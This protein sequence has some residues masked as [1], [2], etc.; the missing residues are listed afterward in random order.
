VENAFFQR[1]QLLLGQKRLEKLQNL[2][3]IIFG[4]GGVGSWCAE[5]LIRSGVR[6]LTI[7]D[8]DRVC[9]T[10]V[11]RQLQAT[12]MT[13][14]QVKTEVLKNRLLE[15][16]PKA[17]VNALQKIYEEANHTEFELEKYDVIV[18]AIDSMQNKIHLMRTACKT[19]AF[20]ISSMGAALRIDSTKIRVDEFWK[21]EYCTLARRIRKVMRKGEKPAKKFLCVYSTEI[22]ENQGVS[23]SGC[24][25]NQC[26]CPKNIGDGD[27]E[28]A[29]HEWCSS[30]A[31]ING[32]MSH[33]TAI[34]GFTIAGEIVKNVYNKS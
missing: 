3:V 24:G 10:N 22:M 12:S 18:D 19:E 6:N 28:L 23:D 26:L 15:I 32:S 1:T 2:N 29:N 21:V 16:N 20:F 27:Q 4:V 13:V 5:S 31:Q 11:N 34:F 25:T 33:I 7:V 8:S 14:G 30:K 17:N 9:I